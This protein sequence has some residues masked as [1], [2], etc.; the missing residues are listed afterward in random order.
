MEKQKN[1]KKFVKNSMKLHCKEHHTNDLAFPSGTEK[2][3]RYYVADWNHYSLVLNVSTLN[4]DTVI[5]VECH[6][7]TLSTQNNVIIQTDTLVKSI[8]FKDEASV[9]SDM[10]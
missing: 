4:A 8:D 1:F 10:K 2:Y 5:D 3:Q 9:G 6:Q 7:N